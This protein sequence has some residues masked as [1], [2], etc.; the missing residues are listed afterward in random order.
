VIKTLSSGIKL[1]AI[2]L[3]LLLGGFGVF[4]LSTF[5]LLPFIAYTGIIGAAAFI[6]GLAFTALASTKISFRTSNSA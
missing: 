6:L 4:I 1:L 5:S 3:A 2:G